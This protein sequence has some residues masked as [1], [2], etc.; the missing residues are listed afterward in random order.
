MK[1]IDFTSVAIKPTL[2]G[3]EIK[4]NI[5][6]VLA[7]VIYQ[8]ATTIAESSFAHR[9]YEAK[10]EIEVSEEEIEFIKTVLP[11]FFYWLQEAI[12]AVIEK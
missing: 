12:L 5:G 11:N 8:K 10:G 7:E 9:L 6:K 3:P 2:G 1:K 4:E